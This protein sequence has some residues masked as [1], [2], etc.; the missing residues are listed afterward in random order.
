MDVICAAV[1]SVVVTVVVAVVI[2]GGSVTLSCATVVADVLDAVGEL[3]LACVA[4]VAVM[5][6]VSRAGEEASDVED[7]VVGFTA[8]TVTFVD[9][10]VSFLSVAAGK[11]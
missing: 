9:E 6:F 3:T 7:V 10:S 11:E 5:V 2:I 1:V 4:V 8:G